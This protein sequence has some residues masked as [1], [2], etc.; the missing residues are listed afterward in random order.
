[1]VGNPSSSQALGAPGVGGSSMAKQSGS[2]GSAG[3]STPGGSIATIRAFGIED[4]DIKNPE[5]LPRLAQE[6]TYLLRVRSRWASDSDL[7]K[8]IG[9]RAAKDLARVGVSS[10]RLQDLAHVD[11]IEVELYDWDRQDKEAC[12]IH[13]AACEIPWEYLLS[14]G[15]R[16]EGRYHGTLISRLF[17]SGFAK[18]RP[19]PPNSVLFVESAPG[20]FDDKYDFKDEEKRIDAAVGASNRPDDDPYRT[21]LRT[22][23]KTELAEK[24]R[25][26]NWEAIHVTGVDTHHA[27][28][29]IDDFYP[30]MKKNNEALFN[31]IIDKA[32]RLPD[33]MILRQ[34]HESELP[35][36]YEELAETL[37]NPTTPP[38]IVTLNLYYS[39]ARIARELVRKGAHVAL[40]FLDEIDDDVAELFF[41]TFYWNWCHGTDQLI[42]SI[43]DAFLM[44]WKA[45]PL[46]VHGTSIVIWM[47]RSIFAPGTE[48]IPKPTLKPSPAKRSSPAKKKA[49]SRKKRAAS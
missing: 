32:G 36:L 7:R 48:S 28:W 26:A 10:K 40:G 2:T 1:M 47:G 31:T 33:G 25:S 15:T 42:L 39:G 24:V 13:E 49:S 5:L 45:M 12:A 6:W 3:S 44:S 30:N 18:V 14:A 34:A 4:T 27:G 22:P 9:K 20:R 19:H 37:V 8:S 29:I 38:R 43:P 35:V 41:Q 11:R 46:D 23:Q 16:T 17:S 21:I